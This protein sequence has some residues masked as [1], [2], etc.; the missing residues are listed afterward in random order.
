MKRLVPLLCLLLTGC[1]S[2]RELVARATASY[3]YTEA[4]YEQRCV[5]VVGPAACAGEQVSLKK[6]KQEVKLCNDVQKIG[7]LPKE[8]KR[9][10]KAIARDPLKWEE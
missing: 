9:N 10:L 6:A 2:D 8:A 1:V 4:H 7:K 3:T 5:Q